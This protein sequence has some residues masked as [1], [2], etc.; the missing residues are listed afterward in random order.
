MESSDAQFIIGGCYVAYIVIGLANVLGSFGTEMPKT[1]ERFFCIMGVVLFLGAGACSYKYKH[2]RKELIKC[3]LS[4][5]N[6]GLYA[7]AGLLTAG[8]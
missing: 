2:Q 8:K 3:I 7:I 5:S 1:Q 6:A 4:L